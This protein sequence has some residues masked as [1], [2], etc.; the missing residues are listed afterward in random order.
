M[1]PFAFSFARY[2]TAKTPDGIG[3]FTETLGTPL[4]V[5]G[6]FSEHEPKTSLTMDSQEDVQVEDILQTDDGA[7]YR[8]REIQL[9]PGARWMK[10]NIERME[11][12]IHP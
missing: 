11:R 3:G 6:V 2:R 9:T 10:V 12:P 5:F 7:Q 1:T 8:V 4:T